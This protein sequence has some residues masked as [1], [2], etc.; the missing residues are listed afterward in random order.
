MKAF[1]EL[2]G[3]RGLAFLIR[4][5]QKVPRVSQAGVACAGVGCSH[6]PGHTIA[7]QIDRQAAGRATLLRQNAFCFSIPCVCPEPVLLNYRFLCN[8]S[9]KAC[10]S[11]GENDL[12]SRIHV[13]ARLQVPDHSLLEAFPTHLR[14]R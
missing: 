9:K 11:H 2:R 4:V 7:G 13:E 14:T 10:F 12:R 3:G 6:Q 1:S 8:R 5:V